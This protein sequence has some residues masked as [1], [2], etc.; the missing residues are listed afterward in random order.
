MYLLCTVIVGHYCAVVG[1]GSGVRVHVVMCHGLCLY[2]RAIVR[3]G[4]LGFTQM[5]WCLVMRF[6]MFQ[7]MMAMSAGRR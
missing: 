2:W 3:Y 7:T 6:G 4:L 5:F 1:G